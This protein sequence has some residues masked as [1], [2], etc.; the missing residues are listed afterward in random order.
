MRLPIF[1]LPG[2]VRIVLLLLLCEAAA[3]GQSATQ[4]NLDGPRINGHFGTEVA[5]LPNGNIVIT[6]PFYD[7]P[8]PVPINGVGAVFL[9]NGRTLALINMM[10]GER[11]NAKIGSRIDVLAN[12]NFVV[13]ASVWSNAY[14]AFM[15]GVRFCSGVTGCGGTMTAANSLVGNKP[16]DYVGGTYPLTNGNYVVISNNWDNGTIVDA[17]ALT[18]CNGNSGCTGVI[19]ASNSLIGDNDGDQ[20]GGTVGPSPRGVVELTNGNYV[21]SNTRWNHYRGAVTLCSGTIGCAGV[22]SAENSLVGSTGGDQ[23][24]GDMVGYYDAGHI[25]VTPL[26]NGNFVVSSSKWETNDLG[27]S[28]WCNGNTGCHGI[29]T[30]ENSLVGSGTNERIGFVTPLP[31]GNYV[32]SNGAFSQSTGA[33]TMCS[34]TSGCVGGF[35]AEN[36]LTG[37]AAG[38]G[39]GWVT[40]LSNGN[41]LVISTYWHG[42]RGSVTFRRGDQPLVGQVTDQNSLV[43]TFPGDHVGSRYIFELT[44][45]NYVVNTEEWGQ[46]RGA[47]TFCNGINGCIGSVDTNNS[48]LGVNPTGANPGDG[49]ASYAI[50]LTNGNYVV[51]TPR[52]NENRGAATFCSGMTGCPTA[53][54]SE[55]SLVGSTPGDLV[56]NSY[57]KLKALANGNYV[58]ISENWN[59]NRGAVTWGNGTT[60]TSGIVDVSNSL[61]GSTASDYVGTEGVA[62]LPSGDYVVATPHWTNPSSVIVGAVTFRNG[63]SGAGAA[64]SSSNSLV[65]IQSGDGAGLDG[66]NSNLGGGIYPL[67]NSDYIVRSS[68]FSNGN[69]SRAGAVSLSKPGTRLVGPISSQNSVLATYSY[70]PYDSLKFA[71]DYRNR[72]MVVARPNSNI[73]SILR[74]GRTTTSNDY[75]GDGKTDATVYRPSA[76]NW[77]L[78]RSTAGFG[79]FH[80]GAPSDVF[81]PADYTGD[82]KTDMAVFR[83]SSGIWYVL[84]SEDYTFYGAGF[85]SSGDIPSPGDFDGDGKADTVVFRPSN[86][87]WYLNQST[88]GFNAVQ[89]GQSGDV[90][91]A[92]DYDG[93]GKNDISVYRPTQGQWFRLNS[94]NGSFY[95]IQ[96][97]SAGDQ[98]VPA[99]YT[100]D[101]KTDYAIFRPS[102]SMWYILRSENNS[103]YGGAFGTTGDLPAP[104]DY[105]GDGKADLAVWRPG[106]QSVF[107]IMGTTSGFT[108]IPWGI[109]EDRPVAN[110]Y[111]Y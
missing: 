49:Y 13:T 35:T 9:Y 69:I 58:V 80:F 86:G 81:A 100:G 101:G 27:A 17:G 70:A 97:G 25:G 62:V 52:W 106:T 12:G 44:N 8:G 88:A 16:D 108:A 94:N 2:V 26:S 36:S 104:G 102:T 90:P 41:F 5:V 3:A 19:S 83:P 66:H 91:A 42:G 61:V 71:Y 7:I 51:A 54:T 89:F 50:P 105:D 59:L 34:G 24:T 40:P 93:D 10:T 20:V 76:G 85:G 84:R 110:A 15:N 98:I 75:D 30:A 57:Q 65:G 72:Q 31:N 11:A 60:G 38:D 74:Y 63:Q 4:I 55:N 77:Y 111:V 107:Y 29:V 46:G 82:G 67:L 95:G 109:A 37:S 32:A 18:F 45:G 22:V 28:T 53:I 78:N 48:L 56:S 68:Y 39:I 64:I 43:G 14:S 33:V 79:A 21:L 73:V 1:H 92:G 103:F 47:S 96:F 23:Q 6:D 99:D 87:T